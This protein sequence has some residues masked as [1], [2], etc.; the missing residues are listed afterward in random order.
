MSIKT[1]DRFMTVSL[2]LLGVGSVAMIAGLV[3]G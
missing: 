1:Y 2:V 3:V